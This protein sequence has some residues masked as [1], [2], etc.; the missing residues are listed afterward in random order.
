M[1]LLMPATVAGAALGLLEMSQ[2]DA[3]AASGGLISYG[4][5]S[6]KRCERQH[7]TSTASC[8]ELILC[9]QLHWQIAGIL[10]IANDTSPQSNVCCW[11]YSNRCLILL[12]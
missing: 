5:D 8:Y 9:R 10:P 12:F 2:S 4:I 7:P 1:A 6:S 11:V 3:D